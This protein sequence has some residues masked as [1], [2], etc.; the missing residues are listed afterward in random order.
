MHFILNTSQIIHQISCFC[1]SLDFLGS[2]RWSS[3]A[4]IHLLSWSTTIHWMLYLYQTVTWEFLLK[5]TKV[6][7]LYPFSDYLGYPNSEMRHNISSNT[8]KCR[9]WLIHY[10][11]SEMIFTKPLGNT[12]VS[13]DTLMR[14]NLWI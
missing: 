9:Q 4:P 12:S 5:Q 6:R 3:T 8:F 1:F 2:K 7:N 14:L 13:N 10:V 11:V